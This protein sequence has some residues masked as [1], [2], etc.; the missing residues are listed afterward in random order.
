MRNR[1]MRRQSEAEQV[2]VLGDSGRR[3]AHDPVQAVF[4]AA[5]DAARVVA[6]AVRVLKSGFLKSGQTTVSR[7]A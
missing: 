6:T 5:V 2:G 4:D 3:R 1:K 7:G